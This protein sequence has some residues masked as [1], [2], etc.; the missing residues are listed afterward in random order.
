MATRE[1]IN[2]MAHLMRRAGFG[3]PR[4]EIERRADF[5]YEETIEELLAPETQPEVDMALFLRY[6]PGAERSNQLTNSQLNWLYRMVHTPRPLEEK[7]ALFWHYVFATGYDKVESPVELLDQIGMFRENGM[8]N[9]HDM[10]FRLSTNPTMIYWLDNNEN[11]R[12]A[13][14]ENW[15]REL[16]ELFSLGVGNYTEDDVKECARAFTGWTIGYKIHWLL[17]GPHLWPFEYHPEDH[18]AS[19]KS[20]LGHHGNFNGEDIIDVI[21]GQPATAKFVA[22][23]LY[24]FFVADEP[25]VPAW[26]F[27]KPKDAAAL[28]L[29]ARALIEHDYEMK[30]VLRI[31]FNS[32]FFKD[33]LYQKVRSPAEVV[34]GT[35]RVTGDLPGPA[36]QWREV[37]EA[38]AT[39]GQALLNPPSVEGWHTG[40]EWINSGAL[41]NRVNFVSEHVANPDAAGVKDIIDRIAASNGT[42]MSADAMVDQCLDLVGPV[43]VRDETRAEL[44]AQA[45]GGGP[46]SWATDDL[47]RESAGRVCDVLS[48]IASTREYQMG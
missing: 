16:L 25:Q 22:R 42:A 12:R 26:P 29:L 47:Y 11:H 21:M 40:R 30:P 35:L 19:E 38:P 37:A 14:N 36:P 7:M 8:G 5:G 39:M 32:D 33:A 6:H 18:D 24:S 43:R 44:V 10:L 46:I 20:F 2:L 48:L 17:W 1:D 3:A 34:A 41:V 9:F 28:S 45:Q 13:P 31:L 27:E 4:S 15:G 23:H